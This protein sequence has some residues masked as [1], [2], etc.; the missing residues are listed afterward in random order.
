MRPQTRTSPDGVEYRDLNGNETM[1]P[2]ENPTLPV[3]VRVADLLARLSPEE[4]AGLLFHTVIEAGPDGSVLQTPG[5]ISKSP[6]PAVVGDKLLNHFNV[7]AL[8]TA[9]AAAR[10][11][12]AVQALA[13][14][15]PH[16]IP[17]TISSDPRHGFQENPGAS[18]V[19]GSF[20]QWPEPIGL[21]AIGD[22]ELARLH[23]D[24]TRQEYLAVG[25]RAALH[26][27]ADLATEPR[28]G[29][30]STTFGQDSDLV[31]ELVD[32][33]LQGL[34]GEEL[35]PTGVAG[36]T[37]HFP[38]GGPQKDGEDPHFP[39]GREQTY[40]GGRFADHLKPFV[41]AVA[42]GTS[43]MMPYYGM[44]VGLELDGE[45]IEQVGFGYN[46]QIVTGL[47]RE[48]LGF[49]GVVV[50][51][52]ELINDNVVGDLVL[53][54]RAWGVED[55]DPLGRLEKLLD[56]GVDQFGGEEC[57][58]LVLELLAAG[59]VDLQRIDE[60]VRRLLRVKFQLG[61]FDNPY[62][63]ED[64][65]TDVVGR[66]DFVA[67][68]HRAQAESMTVLVNG[69]GR[70]GPVLPL[71]QELSLYVEGVD[72]AVAAEYCTVVDDPAAADLALVRVK[73]PYE[74][75]NSYFLE[76]WFHAGSLEFHSDVIQRL[77]KIAEQVPLVVDV[78][79]DRPAIMTPITEIAAGLVATYGSSDRALLDAL[80]KRI[81]PRGRLPFEAPRSM[82]AVAVSRPD[83][84]SD[85]VHPLFEVG[86]RVEI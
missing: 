18:F 80:T 40:T 30:Q 10:W 38:G 72:R 84:P 45:P 8:G 27:T 47:L 63:D 34:Q 77:G 32:A 58:E 28:W 65:A 31:T 1:D 26:P 48:Q 4:K 49:D 37:K 2:Y 64:A 86:H 23:G 16:G 52:W 11:H 13:E 55:L 78:T 76:E 50:T 82:E 68:G 42:R 3:E 75:R 41:R 66:T 62:V 69:D 61:L 21:G 17:V 46:K 12:N 59:R 20:S 73:A 19:A 74:E 44:P 53:P 14:Q 81:Q 43:A 15:T 56:A 9:S 83:V 35:G 79:L 7:H 51:D 22:V 5:Q 70:Q 6:T 85:T 54:A 60:S 36:T 29:R 57:P 24:V 25:I 39:Y 33:F 71:R 67:A